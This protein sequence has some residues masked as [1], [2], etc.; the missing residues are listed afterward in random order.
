MT[1]LDIDLGAI[2]DVLVTM[3][4]LV[5]TKLAMSHIHKLSMET[6]EVELSQHEIYCLELDLSLQLSGIGALI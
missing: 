2:N 5:G 3:D 1:A 6:A 4:C